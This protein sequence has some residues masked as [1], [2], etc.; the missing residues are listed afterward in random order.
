MCSN[1]YRLMAGRGIIIDGDCRYPELLYLI[2]QITPLV[3]WPGRVT[4]GPHPWCATHGSRACAE[5]WPDVYAMAE[6]SSSC[7]LRCHVVALSLPHRW[8][9]GVSGC[10][11]AAR[12][13]QIAAL[14]VASGIEHDLRRHHPAVPRRYRWF[15]WNPAT[16]EVGVSREVWAQVRESRT[17]RIRI[18][19]NAWNRVIVRRRRCVFVVR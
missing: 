15:R 3:S 9:R 11:A 1:G 2:A 6:M 18:R 8:A 5:R 7:R 16:I 17:G 12:F 4:M 14:S 19:F 10:G 13:F